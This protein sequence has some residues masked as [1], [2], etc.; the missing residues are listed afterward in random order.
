MTVTS[1]NV[2]PDR[3]MVSDSITAD[4]TGSC[5]GPN[6]RLP[7]NFSGSSRDGPRDNSDHSPCI[8]NRGTFDA[9]HHTTRPIPYTSSHPRLCHRSSLIQYQTDRWRTSP[10]SVQSSPACISRRCVLAMPIPLPP[11]TD[12]LLFPC[13]TGIYAHCRG[14]CHPQRTENPLF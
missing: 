6:L 14:E 2:N 10:T 9:G 7:H 12:R 3:R 8:P 13:T 11:R 5:L 1:I 4:N